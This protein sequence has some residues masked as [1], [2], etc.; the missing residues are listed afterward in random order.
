MRYVAGGEDGGRAVIDAPTALALA[1]KLCPHL[2]GPKAH[3][4]ALVIETVGLC[5]EGLGCL[6]EED[7]DWIS[8]ARRSLA[9]ERVAY[10]WDELKHLAEDG[11]RCVTAADAEYPAN[12]RMI[13]DRPPL[14]FIRGELS[15]ADERAIAVVGTRQATD[16]G[17]RVATD[18]A[19]ELARRDVTVVAGLAAGIDTAAHAAALDAGGRTIAVFGTGIRRV[20][21]AAN[22]A[23]A[24]NILRRGACVSQF[25][26]TQPGARWTFPVRNIV[27]S[28]LSLGTV[29]VE[30]GPTSGARL[31]AQDALAHAKRL[32]LVRPLVETQSWAREMAERPGVVTMD[33]AEEVV[34][35]IDRDFDRLRTT[36]LL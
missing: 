24:R 33:S 15:E 9:G 18:I 19:A 16:R 1:E 13:H 28:G 25:L 36:V 30:A 12:L 31:Q 26:P 17:V 21:P 34:A 5:P 32:F 4:L 27:T 11:I 14:L 35:A 23:L 2:S 8:A 6:D 3:R 22:R 7:A 20:F 10:W 29:V